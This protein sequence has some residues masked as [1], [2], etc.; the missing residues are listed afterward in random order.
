MVLLC[1]L[2]GDS[3]DGLLSKLFKLQLSLGGTSSTKYNTLKIITIM[4]E[5]GFLSFRCVWGLLANIVLTFIPEKFPFGVA[6]R[7][8]IHILRQSNTKRSCRKH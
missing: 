7:K 6:A 4:A 2:P 1:F 5:V 8:C 3:L